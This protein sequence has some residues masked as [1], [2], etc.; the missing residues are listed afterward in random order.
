MPFQVSSTDSSETIPDA[1]ADGEF[2]DMVTFQHT[3]VAAKGD[4]TLIDPAIFEFNSAIDLTKPDNYYGGL[5]KHEIDSQIVPQLDTVE[6]TATFHGY[7]ITEC[8]A[9]SGTKFTTQHAECTLKTVYYGQTT[10]TV[11]SEVR[12]FAFFVS[13]FMLMYNQ[14]W[15]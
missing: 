13:I 2:R 8:N 6:S 9:Y 7:E 11:I 3:F 10:E 5:L 14:Y 12:V 15:K 4:D 1:P